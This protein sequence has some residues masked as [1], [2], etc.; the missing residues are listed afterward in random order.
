M[1]IN[2]TYELPFPP[3]QVYQA[4]VSSD[5]VIAPATAMHIE[6]VVGGRYCLIIESAEFNSRNDGRFLIVE[7]EQH[8]RYTWEWNGDGEISEI[9]V[10]FASQGSG[11][12]VTLAHSKLQTDESV[13]TH[14]AGWDSY[15]EGF[16]AFLAAQSK[17]TPG[18]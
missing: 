2:K 16:L 3:A 11:T 10:R 5:T 15:I 13:R 14:D 17:A 7:P 18:A 6:A 9:D 8:L 12:L 4:W 1:Q